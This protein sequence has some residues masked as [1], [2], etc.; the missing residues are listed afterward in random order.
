MSYTN[1]QPRTHISLTTLVLMVIVL[2]LA[3][4]NADANSNFK[5]K[6]KQAETTAKINFKV[7]QTTKVWMNIYNKKGRYVAELMNERR[8]KKGKSQ[9]IEVNTSSWEKGNYTVEIRTENGKV[10]KRNLE[11]E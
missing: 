9:S 3:S 6:T 2:L 1:Q 4:T 5:M 11:I 10:W 7:P 8:V